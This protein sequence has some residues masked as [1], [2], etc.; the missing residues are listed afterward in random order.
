MARFGLSVEEVHMTLMAAI[1][2]ETV[3]QTIEGRERYSVNVRYPRDLRDDVDKLSRIYLATPTGAH[4]PLA[5]VA[6]VVVRLGPAMIRDENGRLAGY[7][8]VDMAGRDMGSY[9][10]D[11]KEVLHKHLRLPSGYTLSFSGQYEYMSRVKQRMK[12]VV[13][14]TLFLIILLLYL[15]TRSLVKTLI[16]LLAVPFSLVGAIWLLYLLGYNMSIGA[17]AGIIALLGV[18]AETGVIMLLYLDLAYE[19][20]KRKGAMRSLADLREALMEGAVKRARP[21]MMTVLTTF[22]GLLPIMWAQAHETGADV[23]KRI[24]APM[25]GGIFTSF[26]MELLVY[27]AV[28]LLWKWHLEMKR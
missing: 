3:T 7:V 24:A 22:I 9:V 10:R 21:K 20:R 4:I 18:D 17:W 28:F 26:A 12:L 15:N 25:V 5:Q 27:P 14:L 19:E 13:P 23:M 6:E 16:V 8:Y 11:V 2:G 1:G